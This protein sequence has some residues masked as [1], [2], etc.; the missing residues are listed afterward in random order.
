MKIDNRKCFSFASKTIAFFRNGHH[1]N[2]YKIC[3][4][5]VQITPVADRYDVL[6]LCL[7]IAQAKGFATAEELTLLKNLAIW[8][9]VDMDRFREMTERILPINMHEVKDIEV[10]LGVTPDMNKEKTRQQL[11]KQFCKW[12]SRV[13]NSNRTIQ[14]QADQM[15]KLIAEA[16]NQYIG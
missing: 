2:T 10:I 15:L 13:T 7:Y 16:R 12:N 4:E 5:V 8:L 9:E 14:D 1:L 3:K 11:N 6:E